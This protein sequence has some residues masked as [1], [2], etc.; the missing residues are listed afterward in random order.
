MGYSVVTQSKKGNQARFAPGK[1]MTLY[2]KIGGEPAVNAAVDIFYRKVLDDKI[3]APMFAGVDMTAQNKKQRAF[4]TLLFRAE[5]VGVS[6]YMRKA[7]AHLV[8]EKGLSDIHFDA[9]ANHLNETLRELA[10]PEDLTAQIMSAAASL[11]NAVL[12]R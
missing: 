6:E 4:F 7:H 1:M 5:A 10:V 3:L 9:V 12:N 2:E 11:R 8:E